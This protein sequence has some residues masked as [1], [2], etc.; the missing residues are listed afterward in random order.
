[1]Y[2]WWSMDRRHFLVLAAALGATSVLAGCRPH[3]IAYAQA[4]P[5]ILAGQ[6]R[7]GLLPIDFAN[8]AVGEK[9]END[10]LAEK[11]DEQRSGWA[12][13]K[14]AIDNEFAMSIM[15]TATRDG[16]SVVKATGPQDAPFMI[17]AHVER[18]E[19]GFFAFIVNKDSEVRMKVQIITPDG[20]LIDEFGIEHKTHGT[21]KTSSVRERLREDGK[22]LGTYA[23]EYLKSRVFPSE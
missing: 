12:G 9:T 8:L 13:D 4:N 11:D 18:I 7:F 21:I 3:W 5:N 6:G 15:A 23:A 22:G 1:M 20:T 10:Y 17:R 16:I 2:L 14:V 19:P